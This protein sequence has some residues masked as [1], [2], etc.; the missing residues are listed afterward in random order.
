MK[1]GNDGLLGNCFLVLYFLNFFFVVNICAKLHVR[2]LTCF[3]DNFSLKML[4]E[5][6]IITIIINLNVQ[7][8]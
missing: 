6:S 1:E 8:V 4:E 5:K 7:L 3:S 2:I